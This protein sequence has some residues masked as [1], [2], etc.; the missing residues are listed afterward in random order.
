MAGEGRAADGRADR[1]GHQGLREAHEVAAPPRPR[2]GRGGVAWDDGPR[3]KIRRG[4]RVVA[5]AVLRAPGV[6][7]TVARRKLYRCWEPSDDR[8][9]VCDARRGGVSEMGI[10]DRAV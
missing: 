2:R 8:Y 9:R 10:S 1:R 4:P 6:R 3:R 5:G 7:R